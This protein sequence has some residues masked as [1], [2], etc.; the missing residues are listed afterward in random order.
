MT[1]SMRTNAVSNL[2]AIVVTNCTGRKRGSAAL[3][4]L[5][6]A[7]L[8]G[9]AAAVA[10]SWVKELRRQPSE[11]LAI[12]F[13]G[14]RSFSE[15]RRTA[16]FLDA[17]LGVVSA[18][19]GLIWGADSIPRYDLTISEGDNSIVE[20][21]LSQGESSADWW[22]ALNVAWQRPQPFRRAL[23]A[24]PGAVVLLALPSTY[25][26]MV[27]AELAQ[28]P[29]EQRERLRIFTSE[30]GA[31]ALPREL[32]TQAMPYDERLEGSRQDKGTRTDFAQRAMRH[33]VTTLQAHA[34]PIEEARERVQV[35]LSELSKPH[36]PVREKK[37]DDEI[38]AT[39][40][41]NWAEHRGESGRLLKFLRRDAGFACE[42]SR[43]RDLWRAVR[44][45]LQQEA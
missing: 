16:E 29:A 12:N 43:F 3:V 28:L 33:F 19:L 21:L 6:A 9:S 13:Y 44:D 7:K 17:P 5:Q 2:A 15:A 25:L 32:L 37:T 18:G 31:R 22:E 1:F 36:V 8:R 35:A 45:D 26:A 20:H 11:D 23:V 14:G 34:L 41:A 38:V 30:A 39:L 40:K 10:A 24:H 27:Q 4:S 42:Q